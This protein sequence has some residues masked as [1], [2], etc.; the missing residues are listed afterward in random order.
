MAIAF[1][2]LSG[3]TVSGDSVKPG[4]ELCFTAEAANALVRAE[5]RVLNDISSI[6]VVISESQCQRVR[7]RVGEPYELVER[8]AI[9]VLCGRYELGDI[10]RHRWF[11]L[12]IR[13]RGY[14]NWAIFES[15]I[16]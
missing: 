9:T 15:E 6:V 7:L 1:T 10:A 12:V 16:L 3:R 8:G 2:E 4:C 13:I 5:V 14:R 11:G